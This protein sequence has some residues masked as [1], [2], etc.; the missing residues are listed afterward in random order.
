MNL[1]KHQEEAVRF[2]ME[3]PGTLWHMGL[4]TGKSRCAI[5]LA[6][7]I[8]AKRILILCPL[9]VIPGWGKQFDQFDP[10][11]RVTMLTKGTVR[12]KAKAADKQADLARAH[13]SP[14]AVVVNYESARNAPL[15]R[16]LLDQDWDL[17]VLDE[18]H[19]IKSPQGKTSKFVGNLA[20]VC[21]KRVALTGTPMPHSPLDIWAQSRALHL[22][23]PDAFGPSFFK[24]RL[25]YAKM[26]GFGGKQVVGYQNM[27]DLTERMS[28]WT[29][30]ADRSVLDLP[31]A[32]HQTVEVALCPDARRVYDDLD[33]DFCARVQSGEVTAQ[34]ALVKLLRLQQLTSGV[35]TIEGDM[36]RIVERVD[37]SKQQA[38]AEIL[39]ALEPDEPVVVF[40]KFVA[41]MD[42]VRFAANAVDR[43][44]LELSGKSRQLEQWQAGEAPILGVQ[45]QSGGTGIDLTRAAY[46]V[47]LSTGFNLGDYEQ[48]LARCHRPGQ[49]KT[50]WYYH[51]VSK[52]TVDVRVQR[53]LES[54]KNL[55]E[56]ILQE[57]HQDQEA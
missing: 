14:H 25:R 18:S 48:S 57:I 11:V 55:V 28:R 29:Y 36:D 3:R 10:R 52:N 45:I 38:L 8:E 5:E 17:L 9:S 30:Q 47:Y 20:R 41:D 49:K 34:N 42:C 46:C 24:F 6:K 31:P 35:V 22:G 39:D 2:A 43:K 7:R 33:Q 37:Y 26:G 19:K 50:V 32:I 54:R 4:G 23:H 53:A 1:W 44:S 27:E 15:S 40:G 51:I 16:W 21:R 13:A 56:S 12:D